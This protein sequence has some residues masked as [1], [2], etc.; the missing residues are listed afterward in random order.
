MHSEP[1]IAANAPKRVNVGL[2]T[3]TNIHSTDTPGLYPY[4]THSWSLEK[5]EESFKVIFHQKKDYDASFSLVG[6][7]ASIA[8]AFRRI[9]LAEVPTMAVET[10]YIDN[11][12]S[13]I[14]DEVLAQRLGLV[15]LTGRPEGFDQMTWRTMPNLE[16]GVAGDEATDANTIILK[17]HKECTFNSKAAMG[18]E[19]PLKLYNNAHI[20]A[21]DMVWEPV[22]RQEEWFPQPAGVVKPA[23]P[24]ILLAKMRP[25]Q[26]MDLVMHCVKGVGA[27]HAKFSPVATASY[28]LHPTIDILAPIL[29]KDAEKFKSC[30]MPGV[31]RLDPVTAEDMKKDKRYEGHIGEDKAVVAN[32]FGDSVSRECLRHDEFKDKVK[33]GRIRDHFIFGIE[34]TGQFHSDDLFL[35]AVSVLKHKCVSLKR[36]LDKLER[37]GAA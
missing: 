21:G 24:D 11:N 10:V 31:I 30:F 26:A 22:G 6:I 13:V 15:P 18:E 7:D 25:G 37:H 33:L 17:L 19:D 35:K 23:C 4:E 34:S 32:A 8:N 5:F 16:A 12:T 2:E 36:D 9:L 1:R 27:D 28:R 3:V 29:D 20:Y 14:H